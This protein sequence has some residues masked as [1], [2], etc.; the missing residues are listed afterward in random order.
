M[1]KVRCVQNLEKE[2]LPVAMGNLTN[3][4]V[5]K[6]EDCLLQLFGIRICISLDFIGSL[7]N[8]KHL[9]LS[10]NRTL[11]YLPESIDYLKM[12]HTLNLSYC[13]ELKCLPLGW[14]VYCWT[15]A[16]TNWL[17]MD[18][19][20]IRMDSNSKVTFYHILIRIRILSDTNTKQIDL[21]FID[22]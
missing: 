6:L 13:S 19:D 7:T 1:S 3:L 4:K 8:L 18:S 10:W 9:D 11:K 16:H 17:R 5:L 12:L 14:S 22:E 2:D 21:L 15:D 20:R